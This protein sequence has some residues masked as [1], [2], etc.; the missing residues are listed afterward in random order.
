MLLDGGN[1][2][3][4]TGVRIVKRGTQGLK[5]LKPG[6]DEKTIQQGQREIVE[7]IKSWIAELKQRR[8]AEESRCA[9]YLNAHS[10]TM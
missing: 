2:L 7:T 6:H 3:M 10:D 4:N 9:A 5:T 8:L 1:D